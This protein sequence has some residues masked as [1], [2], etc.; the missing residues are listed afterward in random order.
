[1]KNKT[2]FLSKLIFFF[3]RVPV[4]VII[5][6][7]KEKTKERTSQIVKRYFE[8]GKDILIFT[9]DDK[10]IEKLDFFLK[11]SKKPIFVITELKAVRKN[12]EK[13]IESLSYQTI[14]ILNADNSI[15]KRAGKIAGLKPKKFGFSEEADLKPVKNGKIFKIDYNGSIIPVAL[16]KK[17]KEN[18]YTVLG[19]IAISTSL[20]LNLVKISQAFKK[21]QA[22][23][24]SG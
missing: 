18:I 9:A 13:T 11:R 10:N 12:I 4:I 7:Q 23:S 1:M 6:E 24:S 19:A 20:G 14:L 15:T 22:P 5:G 3:K 17:S 8:I 16:E 2:N 21:L